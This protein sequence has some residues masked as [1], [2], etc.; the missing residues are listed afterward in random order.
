MEDNRF[1]CEVIVH[2]GG[3][4][5]VAHEGTINMYAAVDIVDAKLKAQFRTFKD[6]Y[7]HEPRR[8]KMLGRLIG[9]TSETDPHTP[10]ADID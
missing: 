7:S 1:V 3:E 5:F 10:T 9:R 6:K 8:A 2:V 4:K